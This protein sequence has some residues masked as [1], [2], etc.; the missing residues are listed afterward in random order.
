[1]NESQKIDK[2]DPDDIV[3]FDYTGITDYRT[4]EKWKYYRMSS[5]KNV[6]AVPEKGGL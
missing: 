2:P 3:T 6:T 1:M 5:F 4:V